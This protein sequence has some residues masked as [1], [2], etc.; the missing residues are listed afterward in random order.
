MLFMDFSRCCEKLEATPGRLD[1]IDIISKELPGLTDDEL[2]VFVRFIM[3]RIFADWSSRKLGI[4]PNLLYE[5]TAAVAGISRDKVIDT[6]NRTGDVGQAVE[7]LL[8][9][10]SQTTFFHEELDLVHVYNSLIA[11]AEMEGKKSQREKL[12]AVRRLLGNAHPLEGRYL[13]RIMLEELRIGVGEGSVREAVAKAFSVDPA[14]VEHAM[15][16]LNDMGEVARLAKAGPE[17]LRNVRITL[18][19]PV[20]MMLAQQGTIADMIKEHG[21]IAAEFKYD[22][23]RFQFHKKGNWARMYSRRLED[24]TGA[25]PDVIQQL[26]SAT[27]HDVI[28]DGEVI[29]VKDGKPMPF[30]S[31]LRRFRRRHDIAGAQEAIEMVPNVFDILYLDGETLIDLPFSERRRRLESVVKQ[32]LAPQTVSADPA[33]ITKTYDDALAAGHEGIMIKVRSSPYT[34]GQRGKNWIKIK[35]EVD[36][37]DLAVIGAEWGEGK[38]AHLFGSFLVACQDAGGKLVPLSRVATGFSDEQLAEVYELLKDS[39]V[40]QAG[41]EVTFEPSL[42]FEV[43]Y[44]ELQASQNYEAGFALRF[45]RFIRIRDDKDIPDIETLDSLRERYKRQATSA[46]AYRG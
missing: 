23:S 13:A 5:A 26:M 39:V 38:R 28:I 43:G 31:V 14:L 4:G 45:P 35:P 44:A 16:A 12:L 9:V 1:M 18:F 17:H 42:V 22:G 25:L 11:I 3:G 20:R 34:P 15:Q 2:P 29:A 46:Q 8:S 33:V 24:V 41:K 40:K 10:K 27:D 19:H 30:Q 7:D 36:T 32:Y 21:E 6:I 37:L